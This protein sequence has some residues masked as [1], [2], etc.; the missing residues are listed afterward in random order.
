MIRHQRASYQKLVTTVLKYP[1]VFPPLGGNWTVSRPEHSRFPFNCIS[2]RIPVLH[3][4]SDLVHMPVDQERCRRALQKLDRLLANLAKKPTIESVHKFRTSSRRVEA[5]LDVLIPEPNRNERKLIRLLARN[6]KK[7]GRIRD[8]DVQIATLRNLKIPQEGK[9]KSQLLSL[10]IEERGQRE[11]KLTKVLNGETVAELRKRL[12]RVKSEIRV[13]EAAEPL[14]LAMSQFSRLA[15]DQGP[16]TEKGLHQYRIVGKRARYLAELAG[17]N[18]EAQRFIDK[19][20]RMQDVIG[21][22]HDWLKLTARAEE[23]FA[24]AGDSPLLIMLRNV[25]RAKFRQAVD[26]LMETRATLGKKPTASAVLP[27][28]RKPSVSVSPARAVA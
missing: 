9:R 11:K 8:L 6:R 13:P 23:V 19:L 14:A 24:A 27:P 12:K 18:G 4:A 2:Q 15:H 1:S 3:C 17:R 5:F 28:P 26:I 10:L 25:T 22:W 20:K 7:A 16:L 21:D